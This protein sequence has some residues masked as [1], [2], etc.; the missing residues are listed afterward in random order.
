MKKIIGLLACFALTYSSVIFA[1]VLPTEIVG[2]WVTE[3]SVL[4]NNYL[5]TGQAIY[6][7]SDGIGA[8]VGAPPP[9]G[10]R[11]VSKFDVDAHI[12]NFQITENHQSVGKG[13]LIYDQNTQAIIDSKQN[14]V[15]HRRSQNIP[16]E[17]RRQLGLEPKSE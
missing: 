1:D 2:I 3:K 4:K 10:F 17:V 7:D 16:T 8:I 13:S 15:F 9:I 12:I 6:L 14:T 5:S 11:I